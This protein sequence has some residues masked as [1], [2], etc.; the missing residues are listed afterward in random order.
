M[1][2]K[3]GGKRC[4]AAFLS[5]SLVLSSAPVTMAEDNTGIIEETEN[6][7]QNPDEL[8]ETQDEA[9]D[10]DTGDI[11]VEYVEEEEQVQVLDIESD[12][13]EE[14]VGEQESVYSENTDIN[15]QSVNN[16]KDMK[17]S[18][19]FEG[20]TKDQ[21]PENFELEWKVTNSKFADYYGTLE[22]KDAEV[23]EADGKV[24]LSWTVKVPY[25]GGLDI[26]FTG[27]NY[28]IEGYEVATKYAN[29]YHVSTDF[30]AS[31]QRVTNTYT[32]KAE[33]ATVTYT[34]GI[35]NIEYFKD[36]VYETE[37]GQK[38]PEFQGSTK[39]IGYDFTGWSP[40]VTDTVTGDVTYVAQWKLQEKDMKVSQIF[41]G[42]T[43]DQIPE[44]FELEWKVTNSKF[45]DYYGILEK[46]DAEVTK[47]DGKVTLSW[48]VKVP[49][50][51]G[52]DITFTGKNYEIEGYEAETKYAN[53]YH[54]ST[55]FGASP[56]RVTN[57]YIRKYSIEYYNEDGSQLLYTDVKKSN[58]DTCSFSVYKG[59]EKKEGYELVGW[60][61]HPYAHVTDT[62]YNLKKGPSLTKDQPSMK[63]YAVYAK[64]VKDEQVTINVHLEYMDA[65]LEDGYQVSK[66]YIPVTVNCLTT[67]DHKETGAVHQVKYHD[68]IEALGGFE[69]FAVRKG[70][71]IVGMT[72]NEGADETLFDLDNTFMQSGRENGGDFYLVAKK[73]YT[74]SY[75]GNATGVSS[76]PEGT[77]VINASGSVLFTI[78]D[79]VPVRNGYTFRGWSIE[80]AGKTLYQPGQTVAT[81]GNKQNVTLYGIWEKNQEPETES[82]KDQETEKKPE[83]TVK[84]S[85]ALN[86]RASGANKAISLK[87]AKIPE[88]SGY[89]VYAMQCGSGN[90]HKLVKT[91]KN[92]TSVSWKQTGLKK[93]TSYSYYV[94]AYA[95][96]N[97][98]KV[99]LTKSNTVHVVTSGGK[100][101]NVKKISVKKSSITLKKGKTQT[102]KLNVTYE[103]KNKKLLGHTAK[104]TYTSSNSKVATV[105]KKGVVKAIGKGTC[106]IRVRAE[107]GVSTTVK[108]TVK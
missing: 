10:D 34:D 52:L 15:L 31:P 46:K 106:V 11:S 88:A 57:T 35:S 60:S 33:K 44:N 107:N 42:I 101:T 43:K 21:I 89:E 72:P 66:A 70:Y 61:K 20:I 38:T 75:D 73:V 23:T 4:M 17:V 74:L 3:F 77:K 102:L 83:A 54:V 67:Y 47:A 50:A 97:G 84:T 103:K 68:I 87:W 56:Q 13:S 62:N 40:E 37:V 36:E 7:S 71:E 24:T 78:S 53:N 2:K 28:E 92:K 82:K 51:G 63:L 64:N 91:L 76:I 45:A 48:T 104:Y 85:T 41:E 65:S 26:T 19:I 99:Y 9:S 27:K 69:D 96:V 58:A 18:Q 100:S 98:K 29:N 81:D 25:A 5:A 86:L 39:R 14:A 49:Y 79:K 12:L 90:K 22:K 94:R 108:V 95:T 16:E 93:A 80:K 105:S 55:N 32:K 59:A 1:H 6:L 30:G 8:S